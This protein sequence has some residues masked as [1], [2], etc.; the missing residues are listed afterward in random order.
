M[1]FFCLLPL[2]FLT[3]CST[4]SKLVLR[5]QPA[6]VALDNTDVRY[7]EIVRAYH[8]G[9]YVDPNDD[10]VMHEQH[11]VFRVE[12][13]ARWNLH[14]GNN[15]GSTF[16][17][18]V[19]VPHDAAFIPLPV[20]DAILAEVNSQRIATTQITQEVR[21]FAAAQAQFQGAL[22][23]ARTNLQQTALLQSAIHKIKQ[24]LDAVESVQRQPPSTSMTNEPVDSSGL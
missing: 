9:R 11:T 14:P 6:A 13:N 1:K 5:P 7:P 3:A 21:A 18:V 20:N 8:F 23:Q 17:S 22:Q 15:D 12:E 19:S 24:R 4:A 10:Q 16:F 2:L